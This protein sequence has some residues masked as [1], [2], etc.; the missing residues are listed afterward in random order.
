MDNRMLKRNLQRRRSVWSAKYVF[1]EGIDHKN[2]SPVSQEKTA[3]AKSDELTSHLKPFSNEA[4]SVAFLLHGLKHRIYI[5]YTK[6]RPQNSHI[7]SLSAEERAIFV[8]Q[9]ELDRIFS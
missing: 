9:M 6:I 8:L 3:A 1:T 2:S 4:P 5:Y 7:L